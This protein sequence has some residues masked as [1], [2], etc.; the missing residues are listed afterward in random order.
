MTKRA[1]AVILASLLLLTIPLFGCSK[2]ENEAHHSD[3]ANATAETTAVSKKIKSKEEKL[4]AIVKNT[5]KSIIKPEM[6][7]REKARAIYDFTHSSIRF[8]G[9]SDKTSWKAAAYDGLVS[10]RGDCYTYYAVSRALLTEA[11]IENIE[12]TRDGDPEDP[13]WWN[14]VNCGDGWYHFDA[15]P[16]S[17]KFPF[18]SFMF[19][20]AEAKAYSDLRENDYYTFDGSLYP[21]R[22]TK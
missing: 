20:D 11:G 14:L 6:T 2:Q 4:D 5:V 17:K 18:E 13:H 3:G 1:I 19:T 7:Q 15:C 12:V 16:H 10:K 21:E 9:D 8:T 22:N